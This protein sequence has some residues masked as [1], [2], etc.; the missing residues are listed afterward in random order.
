MKVSYEILKKFVTPPKGVSADSL[1]NT[2]T[3]HTV[4]V[5]GIIDFKKRLEGAVVGL[6]EEVKEHPGADKL[7]LAVVDIGKKS[8]EVVCGGVNLRAGMKVAFAQVGTQVRWHGEA[9]WAPLAKAVI[10]GVASEGMVCAAEELS[11]YDPQAIEHGIM[12]LSQLS[13]KPGMPLA[14]ALGLDDVIIEIDNKSIT[15]RPDL[16]GHLGM[17]RELAAVWRQPFNFPAISSLQSSGHTKLQIKIKNTEYCRRYL[18]IIMSGIKVGP[19]PEWLQQKLLSLG[20]RPI[21]NIVDVTNYVM[22]ELGQPLHAFD[23][24]KLASAEIIVRLANKGESITSLDGVTRKL[25]V[26]TLVIADN[27]QAQA[28]AG[29]MGGEASEV[30]E[31]TESIIIESANF[32][33]VNVRQTSLRLGLRTEASARFE[34]SL[35]P[36]LAELAIRRTVELLQEVV[37]GSQVVSELVDVYPVVPD[38]KNIN[39][40]IN[41]LSQR[42]GCRI[43]EDEVRQIL[44]ALGFKVNVTGQEIKVTI[45]SWRAT[46]DIT[47]PEDL[48]EEVARI[49]GYDKIPLTLPS[50]PMSPAAHEPE[51]D[52]R[53]Q[54]RD[55]LVGVGFVE[56]LSYSFI[57]S[58]HGGKLELVN[59]V[60]KTK[61]FLRPSLMASFA[62]QFINT[63][64]AHSEAVRMFE[65]GRVFQEDNGP[66]LVSPKGHKLPNQPWHLIL[67]VYDKNGSSFRV[68]KGIIE[69]IADKTGE[70]LSPQ[71]QMIAEGVIA[72]IEI[73]G[74]YNKRQTEFEPLPKYP[75]V[76][77]DVSMVMQPEVK[78][79]DIEATVRKASSL[80]DEVRVFDVYEAKNS[81]AFKILFRHPERTL[82]S[83]EVD[84]VMAEITKVLQS[85]FKVTIR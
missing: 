15:H 46:R 12:D 83:S 25:D 81:I 21:N 72:E 66:H 80:I 7:K 29:I 60:D 54:L 64:R 67:A 77:R 13:A 33:P 44:E 63:R 58:E 75:K 22:L 31:Q 51:Q 30:G 16:W 57:G 74:L 49:Y 62:E 82:R 61:Q 11:L 56:T 52:F 50:F 32:E 23:L 2:L 65:L 76:E 59:P 41:W 14:E 20:M 10:R 1:A 48:I 36:E 42:L 47:I 5:D 85:K 43:S 55:L 26:N 84:E 70:Q 37:P 34:K 71:Y 4:E 19:S 3:M 79:S 40:N 6:V 38:V 45:P 39:F 24:A 73:D 69:L 18:G 68:L 17:A 9:D 28:I 35:D 8:L 78:W 27:K 53:W